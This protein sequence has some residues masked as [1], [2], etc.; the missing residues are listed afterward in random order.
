MKTKNEK[1]VNTKQKMKQTKNEK[2]VKDEN[3]KKGRTRNEK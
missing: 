2:Q 3:A 1:L